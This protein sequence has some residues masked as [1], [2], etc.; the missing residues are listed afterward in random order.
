MFGKS[1]LEQIFLDVQITLGDI[2]TF[3]AD[4]SAQIQ[5]VAQEDDVQ[6]AILPEDI[7]SLDSLR[8]E[9]SLEFKVGDPVIFK[10]SDEIWKVE[11]TAVQAPE[12]STFI[13]VGL[14]LISIIGI[15]RWKKR[16]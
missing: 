9:N 3:R 10:T 1:T 13:L 5:V 16:K 4:T 12:A 14:G 11:I 7:L 6:M 15:R 8:W 2:V